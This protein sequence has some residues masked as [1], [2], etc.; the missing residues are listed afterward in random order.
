M[1]SIYSKLVEKLEDEQRN[2]EEQLDK[3]INELQSC[4]ADDSFEFSRANTN[5]THYSA[6]IVMLKKVINYIKKDD[7]LLTRLN[8]ELYDINERLEVLNYGKKSHI[9]YNEEDKVKF[10]E[11]IGQRNELK[12]LI[13][14]FK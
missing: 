13:E 3:A 5:V 6:Q 2:C 14:I 8:E 10:L 4:E 11:L 9:S 12:Y 1:A 7:T